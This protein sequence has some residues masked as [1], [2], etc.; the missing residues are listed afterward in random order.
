MF[1]L[2]SGAS[3]AGKSAV[4]VAVAPLLAGDVECVE[5]C[6]VVGVPARPS[7]EW[8]QQAAEAV[9]Q[10]AVELQ[11]AGRH[12]LL[13]GDPVAA[14]ELL[15]APSADQLDSV[16]VCLLDVSARAQ[17]ARLLARGDDPA[18]LADHHAF[19]DWMRRH[20]RDPGYMQHVLV[21]NSW[22]AMRWERWTDMRAGDARWS[23][24]TIDTSE[25]HAAD[26]ATEVAAWARRAL[27][28]NAPT[29]N[30]DWWSNQPT[31]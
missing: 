10:R 28:G 30:S 27:A 11:G 12:L 16:A 7:K 26:V 25:L 6:E 9:V 4:R 5:L 19:A 20:A 24:E 31:P 29:F 18:L 2:V 13:A 3:G 22:Q 8:R 21:A 23:M 14:G 15:A 17:T 1:L